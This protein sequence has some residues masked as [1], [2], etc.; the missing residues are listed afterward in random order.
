M[1]REFDLKLYLVT[2]RY[3]KTDD[4]FLHQITMACQAGVTLVQL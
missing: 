4:E 3:Q 1:K 2:N